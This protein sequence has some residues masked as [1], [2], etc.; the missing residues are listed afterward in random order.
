MKSRIAIFCI[1]TL[2]LPAAGVAAWSGKGSYEPSTDWDKRGSLMFEEADST[3]GQQVYFNGF[4]TD[5]ELFVTA[6]SPNVGMLETSIL[7]RGARP[8]AMLGVWKDC[9]ADGFVGSG[10]ANYAYP[11]EMLGNTEACPQTPGSYPTHNDG[12]W[13]YE[14]LPLTWNNVTSTTCCDANALTDNL[15]VVW[16][17]RG[18]PTSVTAPVCDIT[19]PPTGTYQSTGGLLGWA[20]CQTDYAVTASF[21]A[22][23]HGIGRS[24]LAF[25]DQPQGRQGDSD[26]AA[27]VRFPTG[28]TE[29][30]SYVSAFDCSKERTHVSA[31]W[32]FGTDHTYYS[33]PGV[34]VWNLT[35]EDGIYFQTEINPNVKV[36]EVNE[37]GSFWGTVNGTHAE[38]TT[39]DRTDAGVTDGFEEPSDGEGGDGTLGDNYDCLAFCERPS[40]A[41]YNGRVRPDVMLRSMQ[42]PARYSQDPIPAFFNNM[43]HFLTGL[44]VR[45]YWMGTE[46]IENTGPVTRSGQPQGGQFIT[47]YA[48]VS[49]SAINT[50]SLNLPGGIAE[51]GAEACAINDG[52]TRFDCNPDNWWRNPDGS[53]I[54]ADGLRSACMSYITGCDP[55]PRVGTPYNLRDVDCYDYATGFQRENQLTFAA[56]LAGAGC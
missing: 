3:V 35:D 37:G 10:E 33:V 56:L 11:V 34:L 53:E 30:E 18:V 22:F 21:N 25:D 8:M 38:S 27:N 13:V 23:A 28:R 41:D 42:W 43:N 20:D 17:D 39:C 55:R 5:G 40:A 1:L 46:N 7:P 2:I 32:P 36:P 51:Y 6:V 15:A 44:S 4:L 45:Q 47:F 50:Y 14:F 31:P 12:L 26:S 24:D 54:N 9:N 29:D 52:Q 49:Q 48:S 19:Q 16:A